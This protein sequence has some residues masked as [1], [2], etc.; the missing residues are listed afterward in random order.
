GA[1]VE[2]LVASPGRA[3]D[4]QLPAVDLRPGDEV[5]DGAA[6]VVDLQPEER[7][8]RRPERRPEEP[9]VVS[10]GTDLHGALAR[11]EG[12]DAKADIAE[13]CQA[14]AAGLDGRVDP[15]PRPVAVD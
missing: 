15:R 4:G 3:G 10:P 1:G 5:I 7:H 8:A 13:L 9:A 2:R 12:V 14:D 6:V 11:T